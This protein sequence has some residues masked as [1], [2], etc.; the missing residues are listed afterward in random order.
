MD[1]KFERMV[2]S[3]FSNFMNFIYKIIVV[4]LLF[5]FT[6]AL[7]LIVF[8]FSAA[9][10]SSYVCM[11]GINEQ[12]DFPVFKTFFSVFK[13]V[14]KKSLLFSLYY[15]VSFAILG[16]SFYYYL[17]SEATLLNNLGLVILGL[18]LLVNLASYLHILL[19]SVYTP[20]IKMIS[21]IKYSYLMQLYKPFLTIFLLIV[22]V[23]LLIFGYIFI[24]FSFM[25]TFAFMSY[26]NITISS[27][28]YKKVSNDHKPLDVL[29]H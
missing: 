15:L 11:K 6:S 24:T 19:I 3:R 13:S 23:A 22:N 1:D 17:S 8:T 2:N 5:L 16:L 26:Y 18:L 29:S 28:A 10:L 27:K 14:Y 12:K 21:K 20:N 25:F 4:N 9:T 7:G